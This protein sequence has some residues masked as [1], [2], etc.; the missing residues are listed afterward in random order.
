MR[1]IIVGA[2]I[3]GLAAAHSIHVDAPTVDV[4]CLEKSRGIGGR[5]ATRRR[6]SATFDHGAQ[7]FRPIDTQQ[8]TLFSDI[9]PHE[10]LIDIAAPVWVFD[11]HNTISPGD[12]SQNALPK[13]VYRDG[14]NVLAKLLAPPTL[15]VTRETLV[16]HIDVQPHRISCFDGNDRLIDTADAILFTP[17]APQT[18]A[19][20][21]AS[22][23]PTTMK[24][25]LCQALS[26]ARYRPCLS[27][28]LAFQGKYELPCQAL[29]N[30]DRGHPFAW[31]A[32]EHLK[33]ESR[34]PAGQTLITIQCA[35]A[36]S[37]Q[38]WDESEHTL[39]ALVVPRLRTLLGFD[40]PEPEWCDRH[41]W[42]YALPDVGAD[43][44]A[45][46]T[47]EQSHGV[48]FTGDALV[49]QGRIQLSIAHGFATAQRLLAHMSIH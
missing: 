37:Q 47:Y 10:Q 45:L 1:V 43:A 48:Y 41:G 11:Q 5:V 38:W 27:V 33:H 18:H 30:L 7:F 9:L 2:G 20:L 40:L 36:A 24:D 13:F 16:H 49:G 4:H 28:T 3:S 25:T 26:I 34:V 21:A 31:V 42:R 29:V 14:I 12:P 46:Q 32:F 15:T 19:I 23:M 35:P 22:H 8:A 17:P 44:L 39:P 6:N